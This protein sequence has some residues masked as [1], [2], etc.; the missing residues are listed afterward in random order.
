M[1][2]A[3]KY[4]ELTSEQ[5]NLLCNGCGGK[6]SPIPTPTF[7]FR[8][9]CDHH[10]YNYLLGYREEDR[11][12]ADDQ[13]YV[14]MKEDCKR[15]K[16]YNRPFAKTAAW[17]YYRAVRQFGKKYFR[18]GSYYLTFDEFLGALERTRS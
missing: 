18:Y 4:L 5:K 15:Q 3:P 10:D 6:G 13:F 16:W 7:F 8:A 2:L 17:L 1:E 14:Q 12:K 11:K 9:S